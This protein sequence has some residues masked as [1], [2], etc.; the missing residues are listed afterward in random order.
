MGV[1]EH[2]PFL[3]DLPLLR[4][5]NFVLHTHKDKCVYNNMYHIYINEFSLCYKYQKLNSNNYNNFQIA[6]E[7]ADKGS[8]SQT[9]GFSSG[10]VWM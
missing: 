6:Y 4:I 8:S 5:W 2:R 9:Y 10:H 1:R 3:L 7:S